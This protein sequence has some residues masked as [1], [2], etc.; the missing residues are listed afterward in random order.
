MKRLAPLLAALMIAGCAAPTFQDARLAQD[1]GQYQEAAEILQSLVEEGDTKAE[2]ALYRLYREQGVGFSNEP[3]ARRS[4]RR[5]ADDKNNPEAAFLLSQALIEDGEFERGRF[6][7]R[8]SASAGYSEAEEY[9][10]QRGDLLNRKVGTLD[11]SPER[12]KQLGDDLYHGHNN[13]EPDHRAA[14]RWYRMAAE[15]DHP[16]AQYM[17]GYLYREGE[18]V[19]QD[20]EQAYQWLQEAALKGEASAQGSLGHL[21]GEG[22]GVSRDDKLAYAWSVLAAENGYDPA[23]KNKEIYLDRLSNE[24]R[25]AAFN[26]IRRLEGLIRR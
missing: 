21:Y 16:G 15:R 6:Y 1:E 10:A 20:F 5:L 9:L 26:E 24:E 14:A 13:I 11:S 25:L 12:Q 7:L 18:G 4:I 2:V 3:E 23:E 8:D 17:L 19:E 22:L